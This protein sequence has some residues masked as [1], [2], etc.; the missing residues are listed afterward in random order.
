MGIY[1]LLKSLFQ[2]T[3]AA[4]DWNLP[5]TLDTW[6]I[7]TFSLFL[8]VELLSNIISSESYKNL[9]RCSYETELLCYIY[10]SGNFCRQFV[11]SYFRHQCFSVTYHIIENLWTLG[12]LGLVS[13]Q[14]SLGIFRLI[15]QLCILLMLNNYVVGKWMYEWAF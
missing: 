9:L 2:L 8:V 15:T 14:Y 1:S 4:A 6:D 5:I 7:I 13:I 12:A 10:T 3:G 11:F